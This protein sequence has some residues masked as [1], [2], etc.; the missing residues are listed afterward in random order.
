[1]SYFEK[2]FPSADLDRWLTTPPE[3]TECSCGDLG[4]IGCEDEEEFEPEEDF[5][6]PD[7]PEDRY[8]DASYEDRYELEEPD[9]NW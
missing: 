1:M 3:D 8:L 6:E 2:P 7:D 9:I 5:L 4:C